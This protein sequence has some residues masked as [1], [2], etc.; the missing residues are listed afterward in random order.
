M[1][2][3]R[4]F[5]FLG[6]FVTVLIIFPFSVQADTANESACASV[7]DND[8]KNLCLAKEEKKETKTG[9]ENKNHSTYYCSL[10][11]NRDLQTYCF[12]VASSN[13]GM[14]DLIVNEKLIQECKKSF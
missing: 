2:F 7:T 6:M 11:K 1:N 8:E 9:Y 14:C 5:L 10:I 4:E 3:F 12:A 13:K